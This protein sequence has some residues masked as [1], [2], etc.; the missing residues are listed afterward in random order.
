MDQQ[1]GEQFVEILLLRCL[2]GAKV[3][4]ELPWR[5]RLHSS[6]IGPDRVRLS[7]LGRMSKPG[8]RFRPTG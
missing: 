7:Q 6:F 8:L 2:Q 5:H 3:L 4:G 1:I